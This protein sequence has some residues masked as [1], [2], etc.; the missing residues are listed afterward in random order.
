LTSK[1]VGVVRDARDRRPAEPG[2]DRD[3]RA[4]DRDARAREHDEA[5]EARDHRANARDGRAEARER[6]DG[7]VDAD[8]V[9][10]RASALRDRQ[11]GASDRSQAA[12]D[13]EA[14]SV[15]RQLGARERATLAVDELTRAHRREAGIVELER[16]G[17]RATRTK[18]GF[19][20]AF[21]DVD[22]LKA[23]NDSL[24]HAAGDLR[25]RQTAA[26]IR[27]HLRSYDL[28]IRYGGDEFVC[29]LPD[30]RMEEA[31]ER[32]SLINVAL[33]AAQQGSVTVGLAEL[34]PDD[35]VSDLIARADEA[36][37]AQRRQT[38]AIAGRA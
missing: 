4:E 3:R 38:Q 21:V 27:R 16:E 18:Q 11:G 12:D 10:D 7:I 14:A 34:Q 31:V 35:S 5:S 33:A 17:E 24:G 37:Y 13:R 6:A 32:F 26:L 8:A 1:Y 19:V 36:M 15:D 29:A 22:N 9:A 2:R 23:T 20:L 28:I 30:M 25:L